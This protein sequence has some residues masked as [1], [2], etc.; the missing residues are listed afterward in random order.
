MENFMKKKSLIT[1]FFTMVLLTLIGCNSPISNPADDGVPT[2]KD[3]ETPSFDKSIY[4]ISMKTA[5]EA[6]KDFV[7]SSVKNKVSSGRAAFVELSEEDTWQGYID[8]MWNVPSNVYGTDEYTANNKLVINGEDLGTLQELYFHKDEEGHFTKAVF[9]YKGQFYYVFDKQDLTHAQGDSYVVLGTSEKL[10][11]I[12]FDQKGKIDTDDFSNFKIWNWTKGLDNNLYKRGNLGYAYTLRNVKM[13]DGTYADITVSGYNYWSYGFRVWI[14]E[15]DGHS[16]KI[17][18]PR[19]IVSEEKKFVRKNSEGYSEIYLS[20]YE[21]LRDYNWLGINRKLAGTN[22]WDRVIDI[23]NNNEKNDISKTY[24]DYYVDPNKEYEYQLVCG[25]FQTGMDTVTPTAGYGE[26]SITQGTATYDAENAVLNFTKLPEFTYKTVPEGFYVNKSIDYIVDR[27]HGYSLW[28][29]IDDDNIQSIDI[30]DVLLNEYH[31]NE[32]LGRTSESVYFYLQ[33]RKD[34]GNST[35][36]YTKIMQATNMPMITVPSKIKVPEFVKINNEGYAEIYFDN[37]AEQLKN[38]NWV[39]INRRIAGSYNWERIG[40]I[41]IYNGSIDLS[42][43]FTDYFVESGKE[44]EY[45]IDGNNF[46]SGTNKVTPTKGYG[47]ITITQGAASYD[48]GKAIL[49]LTTVPEFKYQSVIELNDYEVRE[50]IYYVTSEG[51]DLWMSL[52]GIQNN[53]F[54][55]NQILVGQGE[56]AVKYLDKDAVKSYFIIQFQKQ[57]GDTWFCYEKT[58]QATNMPTFKFPSEIKIPEFVRINDNGYA[59]IYLD[60]YAEQLSYS[61]GFGIDRR[62]VGTN[63]WERVIDVWCENE[64]NISPDITFIDYY[65]D[66]NTEYVY[67]LCCN[68]FQ[69]RVVKLTP[70]N[71]YGEISITPGEASYNENSG[72]LSFTTLPTF[73]FTEIEDS[74]SS[75][76]IIY[77]DNDIGTFNINVESTENNEINIFDQLPRQYEYE[78]FLGKTFYEVVLWVDIQKKISDDVWLHYFKNI[79]VTN[80]PAISFPSEYPID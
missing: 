54:N 15:S 40:Q 6:S 31:A 14:K 26:M 66:S 1:V 73:E 78:R 16:E 67:Q 11:D 77:I 33:I 42:I 30:N 2:D 50:Q 23:W 63:E 7:F 56:D 57:I 12:C 48:S 58:F 69:S 5:I 34:E 61:N 8:G 65:V 79:P 18:Y 4:N 44:Y 45:S 39:D 29:N 52:N 3:T 55:I 80:M 38:S 27:D 35:V 59:E 75:W 10:E 32:Y 21:N 17:K 24:I 64:K 37:Y 13:A 70:R 19:N 47:E 28:M 60:D 9:Q 68:N 22:E 72:I 76:Q 20:N 43:T 62:K 49:T 53:S 51:W 25:N 36:T 71:G 46:R 74:F 41:S